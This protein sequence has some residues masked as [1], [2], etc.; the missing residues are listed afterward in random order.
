MLP[1]RLEAD[2]L[3]LYDS[4]PVGRK[5]FGRRS[6]RRDLNTHNHHRF[7]GRHVV[8]AF[9]LQ[10]MMC[11]GMKLRTQDVP[12][13]D[14][15]MLHRQL[16]Q[17]QEVP[18]PPALQHG[19]V[20]LFLDVLCP[21]ISRFGCMESDIHLLHKE[22]VGLRGMVAAMPVPGSVHDGGDDIRE[23][24][25]HEWQVKSAERDANLADELRSYTA[26]IDVALATLRSDMEGGLGKAAQCM[27]EFSEALNEHKGTHASQEDMVRHCLDEA[28]AFSS[29]SVRSHDQK[30]QD[31]YGTIQDHVSKLQDHASQ[32][33]DILKRTNTLENR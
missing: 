4:R 14:A 33:A 12:D 21:P 28:K 29:H 6:G 10:S 1:A 20:T 11:M 7:S 16:L 17:E 22:V 26:A 13:Y 24:L 2:R 18:L 3:R 9:L 32:T 25:L 30:L 15:A 5:R 8:A 23:D 19:K 31:L 27:Q